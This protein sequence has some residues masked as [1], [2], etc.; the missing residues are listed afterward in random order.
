MAGISSVELYNFV[1]NVL[2]NKS[3]DG[4]ITISQYNQ[5]QYAASLQLWEQYVGELQDFRPGS[6]VSTVAYAK[7]NK[8]ESDI[9]PF[10]I[11][12][13]SISS[14]TS[15]VIDLASL[16]NIGY[17]TDLYRVDTE[18]SPEGVIPCTRVNEQRVANQ[19]SSRVAPPTIDHPFYFVNNTTIQVFPKEV[20]DFKITYVKRPDNKVLKY[21][22]SGSGRPIITPVGTG[23]SD[24]QYLEWN[25]Q[26]F[27]DL[28]VL[29]LAF[30]GVNLKDSELIQFSQ[31]KQQGR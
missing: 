10:R 18:A 26:N 22:L 12:F 17:V 11:P 27:N 16:P 8:I 9:N 28:A 29:I 6:S 1:V 19:I 30:L 21:T 3:Q 7:T 14:N 23:G 24:S 13:V 2:A 15:G 31:L 25:Q 20:L 4:A 5:A